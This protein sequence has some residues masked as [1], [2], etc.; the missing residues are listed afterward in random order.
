MTA[1]S[2]LYVPADRDDMLDKALSGPADAV[3]ADLEDGV[4]PG[5]KDDARG[6]LAEWA[7]R[8]GGAERIWVR[9][10]NDERMGGDIAMAVSS[11]LSR[12][13]V[14]KAMPE[15][16][17]AAAEHLAA[18]GATAGRV[19]ALVESAEGLARLHETASVAAR[20]AI[21]E[22]DLGADLGIATDAPESVWLPL[23]L[24]L[25]VASA[26]AG[27]PGPVG[28]VLTD[29]RNDTL[30][31][32]STAGLASIGFAGRAAIHPQQ[33]AVINRVFTPSGEDVAAARELIRLFEEARSSGAGVMISSDGTMAD[34]ATVRHARLVLER[35]ARAGEGH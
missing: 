26:A 19:T 12:I 35:A 27:L 24:Q 2:F 32:S 14:P 13:Y 33:V 20:L 18:A 30:L 16:V 29:F 11:G 21:G 1:R 10:N 3:I 28:P 23:R 22:A 8:H 5:A 34:E 7:A 4:A 15:S 31:E 9:V 6:T 25:V 17:A